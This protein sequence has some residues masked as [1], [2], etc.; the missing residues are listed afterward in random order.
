MTGWRLGYACGPQ[1]IIA[2]MT[3]I[4]QF[5]IMCAPTNSQYAAIEAL[6]VYKRQVFISVKDHGEGIA[7]ENLSKIWTRFYKTDPSRGKDKKGTGLGLAITKEIIQ[8]HGEYI[9]AVS[10]THLSGATDMT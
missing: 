9:D 3:K 2:Q 5:A 1:E 8:S 7:S 6:D 10:Y 4:H